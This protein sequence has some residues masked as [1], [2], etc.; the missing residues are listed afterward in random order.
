MSGCLQATCRL[1]I[2]TEG[3]IEDLVRHLK[4]NNPQ[5]QRHCASA[6]FQVALHSG[7]SNSSWFHL[8]RICRATFVRHIHDVQL[9]VQQIYNKWNQLEFESAGVLEQVS[10][11]QKFV[12][13]GLT[14]PCQATDFPVVALL[15]CLCTDSV[16][17]FC[18]GRRVCRLSV[19]LSRVR[20]RKLSEIGPKFRRLPNKSRLPSKNMTSDFAQ[21][22]EVAKYAQK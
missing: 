11:R 2:R 12:V 16:R 3:M 4:S 19:S 22:P 18:F 9:I 1:S 15:G 7:R 13:V 5:L 6:I 20:C 8:S 17:A 21:E 10:Q 14:G